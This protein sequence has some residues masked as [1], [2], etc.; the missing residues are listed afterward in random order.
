MGYDTPCFPAFVSWWQPYID[1]HHL[2]P[3]S[4][5]VSEVIEALAID[6]GNFEGLAQSTARWAATRGREI[7]LAEAARALVAA[8]AANPTNA[9][10]TGQ[11]SGLDAARMQL[12]PALH[13]LLAHALSKAGHV[14]YLDAWDLALAAPDG[15]ALA[16]AATAHLQS[17]P[18]TSPPP[19][20]PNLPTPFPTTWILD[21]SRSFVR[22]LPT[23]ALYSVQPTNALH[24]IRT[25][26]TQPVPP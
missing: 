22:S 25:D 24:P 20:R 2:A 21:A 26:N 19:P 17:P 15:S 5:L 8:Q 3:V 16:R 13:P 7:N 12:N 23:C 4:D 1:S 14:I 6:F 11:L 10:L 9:Y 18:P